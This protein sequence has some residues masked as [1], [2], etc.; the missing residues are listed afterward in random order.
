MHP[1]VGELAQH[2][3]GRAIVGDDRTARL[4]QDRGVEPGRHGTERRGRHAD[5]GGQTDN[6]DVLD[7]ALLKKRAKRSVA[8]KTSVRRAV[9][10]VKRPK[11]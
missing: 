6:D 8:R 4:P 2:A 3:L 1:G 10:T 7:A 9:K 5:V 11:K